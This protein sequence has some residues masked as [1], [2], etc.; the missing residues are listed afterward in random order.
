MAKLPYIYSGAV[1]KQRRKWS[2][3]SVLHT[4]MLDATSGQTRHVEH[5]VVEHC[6]V[7]HYV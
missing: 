2:I 4:N 3:T 5:Y 7:E 6:V 1:L